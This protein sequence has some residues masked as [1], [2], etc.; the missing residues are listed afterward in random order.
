MRNGMLAR[1]LRAVRDPDPPSDLADRLEDAIPGSFRQRGQ[2]AGRMFTLAKI[3]AT[4]AAVVGLVWG[5]LAL[6]SGPTGPGVTVAA[7]LD[8]VARASG[9]APAVHIVMR[10]LSRQGEDFSFVNLG[11][12]PQTFE[13]WIETPAA[14]GGVSNAAAGLGRARVTKGDRVYACDGRETIAWH[15]SRGEAIRSAGC[16][17][18]VE[19]FWPAAWVRQLKAAATVTGAEMHGP[20]E[21]RGTARLILSEPG[22][23]V[24][25]RAK[26]FLPEFDRET[27][28]TWTLG[29]NRLTGLRRWVLE[30]GRHLVAETVTIEYLDAADD[31]MFRL[32]LPADVRWV[33]LREAPEALAALGPREV[34]RRFFEAA[35]A[36]DH[37]TLGALGASPYFVESVLGMGLKAV[38]SIGEPFRTGLYPGVYVPYEVR[39]RQGDAARTVKYNLALRDDNLQHR[40]VFDGGI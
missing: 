6:L 40:W 24:R 35:I 37:D 21:E 3:G 16:A 39:A 4:A 8:P 10:V 32:D 20:V 31:A 5:A 19:T 15:P 23:D 18:D 2:M 7:M 1:Q 14:D 27:E 36:G 29:T 38:V 26:A 28:L 12:P 11:G 30:D 33:T 9:S 34:A 25:G 17:V 22:A 13:A